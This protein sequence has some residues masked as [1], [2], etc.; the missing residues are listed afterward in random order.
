[1]RVLAAGIVLLI[2]IALL[3]GL[4]PVADE[5]ATVV[6]GLDGVTAFETALF[7]FWKYILAGLVFVAV[8]VVL[9][10]PTIINTFFKGP[11]E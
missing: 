11:R 10:G 6:S 2:G 5:I 8:L 7:G 1:M 9:I 3:I 4:A